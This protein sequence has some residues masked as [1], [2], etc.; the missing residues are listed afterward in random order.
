M[1]V[2]P[3]NLE[4]MPLKNG[5]ITV[6]DFYEEFAT[7]STRIWYEN[8][9]PLDAL[10]FIVKQPYWLVV[11]SEKNSNDPENVLVLLEDPNKRPTHLGRVQI[12]DLHNCTPTKGTVAWDWIESYPQEKK[13]VRR[14]ITEE[15]H[16]QLATTLSLQDVY[17]PL[18]ASDIL[19]ESIG[20]V[21]RGKNPFNTEI[22]LGQCT[23]GKFRYKEIAPPN[24]HI[25]EAAI[26]E[27]EF[28][29]TCL[30]GPWFSI[31]QNIC[32]AK[33]RVWRQHRYSVFEPTEE[34]EEG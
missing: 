7:G 23:N 25:I 18:E 1:P 10:E 24:D 3:E 17:A 26:R 34:W 9:D 20:I 14:R 29:L 27:F 5:V 15:T 30:C 16:R 21:F 13:I 33:Q 31:Q 22:I 11:V 8:C 2:L 4:T 32:V 12:N 19:L 6:P 28:S